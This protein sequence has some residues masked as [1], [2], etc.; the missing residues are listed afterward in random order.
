MTLS[1]LGVRCIGCDIPHTRRWFD[2]TKTHRNITINTPQVKRKYCFMSVNG[3]QHI[4][5]LI[6]LSLVG[7]TPTPRAPERFHAPLGYKYTHR[8]E[9]AS[10][11]VCSGTAV[12]QHTILTAAHCLHEQHDT[13]NG[14]HDPLVK[15]DGVVVR[16]VGVVVDQSDHA[17][18]TVN[19][20]PTQLD[21]T[22]DRNHWCWSECSLLGESVGSAHV[23]SSGS[24][25]WI[26]W[27]EHL[28]RCPSMV[29][30]FRIRYLHRR[31]RIDRSLKHDLHR[32]TRSTIRCAKVCHRPPII[33][34]PISAG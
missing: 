27:W 34:H 8:L 11:G 28:D 20:P 6:L 13:V 3:T 18:V 17:L 24:C 7:C 1:G 22:N 9:M 25:D 5:C 2:S 29:W 14:R 30:R 19:T 21:Q 16:E 12:S 26:C 15:I 23:L 33:F 10:S 31:W 4:L 32:S